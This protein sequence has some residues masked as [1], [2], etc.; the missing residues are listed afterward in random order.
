VAFNMADRMADALG[1]WHP[2]QEFA[3]T[4]VRNVWSKHRGAPPPFWGPEFWLGALSS[5]WR[6][7]KTRQTT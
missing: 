4:F 2:T 7:R 3:D 1:F 5:A 6:R